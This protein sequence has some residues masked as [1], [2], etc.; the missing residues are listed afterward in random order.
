[1]AAEVETGPGATDASVTA[2]KMNA[3]TPAEYTAVVYFHGM[4]SQRRYEETSYLIDQIDCYLGNQE[5]AGTP[6]GQLRG[7]E[8]C[9]EPLNPKLGQPGAPTISYVKAEL[10]VAAPTTDNDK[11]RFYEVY[12]APVMAEQRSALGV[13]KWIFR[14]PLRPLKTLTSRWR[15]RQRLRRAALVAMLEAEHDT[16]TPEQIKD[17]T[18]LFQAYDEF[19][20]PEQR[21]QFPA[22]RFE[23]FLQFV[24]EYPSATP[25][26]AIRRRALTRRWLDT[27]RRTE[28]RN[29]AL[30]GT[31]ALALLLAAAWVPFLV[32]LL[33]K[34]L[35]AWMPLSDLLAQWN[36]SFT[37]NWQTAVGVAV[38]VAGAFGITR[39]LTD[40]MGDVE[41]WATY[42]ETDSKHMARSKVLDRSVEVLT[43]VLEDKACT[44]VVVIAHSLGTSVAHDALLALRRCNLARNPTNA[45]TGA[46]DLRK[47]EH[48]VTMGS[49]IDKIE[50]FFESYVSNSH[51]YKRVVEKLR[52]DI[53][54]EPFSDN[55]KPYIHWINFWDQGDP[56]SGPLHSPASATGF[57][58]RVDN[59]HVASW[60]FPDP[61]ASHSGY[62]AH[63]T[64]IDCLFKVICHRAASFRTLKQPGPKQPYNYESVYLAS[65]LSE[66]K[67]TR[68]P[69]L[70]MALATPW[71][72]LLSTLGLL[73]G[74]NTIAFAAGLPAVVL[75]VLLVIAYFAGR[76]AG[77]WKPI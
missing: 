60:R 35:L 4:G 43:H 22:G 23:E 63:R 66:P 7:I 37:A 18:E 9:V 19:E 34:C 54:S 31:M 73:F 3:A 16:A 70:W 41:A 55:R 67:G 62:F 25:E 17:Y 24:G 42:E 76:G 56:I 32:L 10:T 33:L 39:F 46:I 6:L 13:L 49:P 8:A 38:F 26:E 28:V 65:K 36:L 68:S 61:G 12:W 53:G 50:Y 2:P 21:R 29:A 40:Y 5:R 59:V 1:M 30:L 48:I 11:L 44:R 20:G 27:Y 72:A 47:L 45:M 51:R 57:R 71:L 77:H 15:E 64:V 58:Q 14:Q 69:L 52:G 75:I 74:S